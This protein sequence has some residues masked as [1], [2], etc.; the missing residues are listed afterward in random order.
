MEDLIST[1]IIK[2][3]FTSTDNNSFNF[4][5]NATFDD[6]SCLYPVSGCT[7]STAT[8]YNSL[9][10]TDDGS[11]FYFAVNLSLKGIMDLT[12]PQGG[13]A[14]KAIHLV[15]TDSIADLSVY[16]IGVANNANGG[17]GQEYTFPSISLNNGDHVLLA[18]DSTAMSNY[19][20]NCFTYFDVILPASNAISQNGNDAV[21]LFFNGKYGPDLKNPIEHYFVKDIS[22]LIQKF[23]TWTFLKSLDLIELNLISLSLKWLP[24]I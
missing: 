23:N 10:T 24:E 21:E 11:C 6:G 16:G 1:K 5:P 15:A 12:V 22:E 9:A 7:D 14:G 18:R 19:F 2:D 4:N 13:S 8:N 3:A 17:D 20:D